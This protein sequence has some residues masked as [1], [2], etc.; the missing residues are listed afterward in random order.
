MVNIEHVH[1]V[2]SIHTLK[3]FLQ[4]QQERNNCGTN[5]VNPTVNVI[6]VTVTFDVFCVCFVYLVVYGKAVI[7]IKIYI[8]SGVYQSIWTNFY[9]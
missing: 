2:N 6:V 1:S 4:Q 5:V 8:H 7:Y 3:K 9:G